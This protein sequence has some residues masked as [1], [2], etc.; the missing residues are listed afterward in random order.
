MNDFK[1]PPDMTGWLHIYRDGDRMN[2]T[3]INSSQRKSQHGRVK[4]V[5]IPTGAEELMA[6]DCYW[7]SK[8]PFSLMVY[9]HTLRKALCQKNSLSMQTKFDGF[10]FCLLNE[11]RI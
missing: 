8:S 4:V 5:S 10:C 11:E 6:V 9:Q 2:E 7:E 1:E 3:W